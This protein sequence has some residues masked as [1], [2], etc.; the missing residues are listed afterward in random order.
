[1]LQLVELVMISHDISN[2]PPDKALSGLSLFSSARRTDFMLRTQ[3][4][5]ADLRGWEVHEET[6]GEH[7]VFTACL[8]EWPFVRRMETAVGAQDDSRDLRAWLASE[9]ALADVQHSLGQSDAMLSEASEAAVTEWE[10]PGP[11]RVSLTKKANS[12]ATLTLAAAPEVR[13]ALFAFAHEIARAL[14][15]V[16][17]P[18]AV[19]PAAREPVKAARLKL[20]RHATTTDAFAEIGKSVA[21]QWFGNDAASRG[22][23]EAEHVHQLRVAQRRL[24]TAL[25]LFPEWIDETWNAQVAPDLKWFGDLLADARDWDVFADTTLAAYAAADDAHHKDAWSRLQRA[26]DAKRMAARRRLQDAMNSPRY[27]A[28]ALSF[29][30]WFSELEAPPEH[31]DR[32][33]ADHVR[34]RITKHYRKIE[35]APDLTTIDA[36]TRHKVR[37][38]AKRL[39]YALEF[40]RSMVTRP[41]RKGVGKA[42]GDL[43]SVLGE[44]NDAA[45]A[46]QR[47]AALEEAGDYQK[48]LAKGF[49]IAAQQMRAL[50]G[51]RIL[52][53][54]K[55]PRIK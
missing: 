41:T 10:A 33:L 17:L 15:F 34:K 28:L 14:P 23:F 11:I 42:L 16:I 31:A 47:L 48:G 43:Q 21:E 55:R 54:I 4:V 46:A 38:H 3:K 12:Q 24:K 45:V 8:R 22:A 18:D 35:R 52:R 30:Q 1:M 49:A 6:R 29:V 32:T 13:E 2:S 53:K 20:A 7:R 50:E 25:K 5:E 51:E 36:R 27:A 44:G 9:A 26:A 39:R 19:D 37:I 40:F